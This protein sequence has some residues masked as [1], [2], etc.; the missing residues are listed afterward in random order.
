MISMTDLM[1]GETCSYIG[2][3]VADGIM[4]MLEAD[5]LVGHNI[6]Y[7]DIPQIEKLSGGLVQFDPRKIVDT[8]EMS[9]KLLPSQRKHS[10]EFW[11]NIL[12]LPKLKSPLF[13]KH[14]PEMTVYCER[15]VAVNVLV[16][17]H[18]LELLW[19]EY[20]D[21]IPDKF[22]ALHGYIRDLMGE[23]TY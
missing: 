23:T 21:A 14:T 8:L 10:L 2:D 18:L 4:V 19:V 13:E 22:C 5:M 9:R 17:H 6:R 11:G 1:T 20:A 7:Y 15:D 12:G 16:F 3:D